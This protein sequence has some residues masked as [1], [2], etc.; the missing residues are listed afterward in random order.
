MTTYDSEIVTALKK[1]I[2]ESPEGLVVQELQGLLYQHFKLK[3]SYRDIEE[4][5]ISNS[6]VF[7]ERDWKWLVRT[8]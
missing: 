1:L 7:T 5:L 2:G 4:T 6:E 3:V 8:P